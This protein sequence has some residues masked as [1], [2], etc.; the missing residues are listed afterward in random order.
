MKK[1]MAENKINMRDDREK[2]STISQ[3]VSVIGPSCQVKGNVTGTENLIIA[4]TIQGNIE[5]GENDLTIGET[6]KV[7][8]DIHAK[9]ITIQGR[10]TGNIFA[11]GKVLIEEKGKMTGDITTPRI[12]IMDGAKFKGSVYMKQDIGSLSMTKKS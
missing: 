4:G 11:S 5:I 2:N 12:S 6:A 9:N 1:R 10:V 7:R 3:A 8:A